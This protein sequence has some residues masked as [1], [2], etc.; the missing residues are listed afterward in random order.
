MASLSVLSWG[1]AER[2]EAHSNPRAPWG[3]SEAPVR[4]P[5]HDDGAGDTMYWLQLYSNSPAGAKRL[6]PERPPLRPGPS[7][8]GQGFRDWGTGQRRPNVPRI[9]FQRG[10]NIPPTREGDSRSVLRSA[11]RG[12]RGVVVWV[13]CPGNRQPEPSARPLDCA[14]NCQPLLRFRELKSCYQLDSLP[15]R[16]APVIEALLYA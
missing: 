14:S 12:S 13:Q 5:E 10:D 1:D 6:L 7:Q 4:A 2:G 11:C 15:S 8:A 9:R 3:P 16:K